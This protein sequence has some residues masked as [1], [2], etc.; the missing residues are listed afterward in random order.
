MKFN[1]GETWSTKKARLS[2]WHSFFAW[3]PIMIT[4]HDCRWMERIERKG[5]YWF[6]PYVG[7]GW[8]WSYRTKTK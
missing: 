1:C 3:Y 2:E 8:N 7:G 5:K 4:D 6:V